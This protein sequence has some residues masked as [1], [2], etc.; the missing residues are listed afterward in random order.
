MTKESL[1]EENSKPVVVS[2]AIDVAVGQAVHRRR[3]LLQ[4]TLRQLARES[5][6][7]A[8]LISRIENGLISPS[9]ST[10]QSL[11]DA[12]DTS[13]IMFFEKTVRTANINFVKA[14]E[15][16]SAKRL[17]PDHL[18]DYQIFCQHKGDELSLEVAD[19]TLTRAANGTHPSYVMRGYVV[20]RVLKGVCIYSC[21]EQQFKMNEGDVLSFDAELR[22]GVLEVISEKVEFMSVLA[23]AT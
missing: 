21:G 17:A 7:S 11:A 22:H 3:K 15:G 20:I 13:V 23:K 16:I 14:G 6:L 8:A 2:A 19:V 18:H 9:L 5:D 10:L 4:M 1:P 12:M